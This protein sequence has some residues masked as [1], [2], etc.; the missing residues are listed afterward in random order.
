[1]SPYAG[2]LPG[3]LG[4]RVDPQPGRG[5]AS[6]ALTVAVGG[7]ADPVG[8]HGMAH[9][10][11]HLMFPRAAAGDATDDH[12]ARVEGAG[13]VCN[14]E[15]HRDHTVF[16][17]TVPAGMLTEVLEW[18]ARRLSDFAPAESVLRTEI[19]VIAE[20]IRGA[21]AAGGMWESALA[22]LYPGSRD[23][24]GTPAELAAA[25]PGDVDAFFR[26]HYRQ[27]SMVLS[28]VGDVDPERVAAAAE[29]LFAGIPS[30][31]APDP[32]PGPAPGRGPS[33]AHTPVP[34]TIRTAPL[35]SPL[36]GAVLG[37]PLPDPVHNRT[38][39]LA[40]VV[41]AETLGRGRLPGLLR[42][43]PL[44]VSARVTCGYHGQWLG[45]AAP[46]L[47][48][49]QFATAPGA[50]PAAAADAWR[51]VLSELAA[52]PAGEAEHRR[53][54]NGLLLAC[55][56]QADSLTARSVTLGRTALLFPTAPGPDALPGE[57]AAVTAAQVSAAARALLHG[58]RSV[59][60]L[61]APARNG[62]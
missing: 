37:H 20:E 47:L 46:D 49:A 27:R 7:D 34:A 32:E 55:H 33:P 57:L 60:E 45:S 42:Q 54:V 18:E 56:R 24:F 36:G 28:V 22:A 48:L 23:S 11:E 10:V 39:Y 17:T 30:G 38:G 58:P 50:G 26:R 52:H 35:P 53:A 40:H 21:A 44:I 31:P 2:R 29:P 3:G 12:V 5:L 19:S 43:H 6:V 51:T 16:H 9:L 4:L 25:T 8:L 41:L 14:A 59:T 61:S 15:T 1:M 13:G 62:E